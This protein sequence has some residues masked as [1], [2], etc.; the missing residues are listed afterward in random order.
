MFNLKNIFKKKKELKV[1]ASPQFINNIEF[2]DELIQ[3]SIPNQKKQLNRFEEMLVKA[4]YEL[5]LFNENPMKNKGHL[6]NAIELFSLA[7]EIKRSKPEPYFYL[8]YIANLYGDKD[9]SLIHI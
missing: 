6:V 9:L 4:I 1:I 2:N 8:S 7:I 5:S 3:K